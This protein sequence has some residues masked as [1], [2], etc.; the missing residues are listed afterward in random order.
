MAF[1]TTDSGICLS[2]MGTSVFPTCG[3]IITEP[4]VE[5]IQ[6]EA[7]ENLM[8]DG[9]CA[10]AAIPVFYCDTER[11]TVDKGKFVTIANTCTLPFTITGFRNSDPVRFS[12]FTEENYNDTYSSGNTTQLPLT[13]PPYSTVNIPTFFHPLRSELETGTAGT[14]ENMIGDKFGAKIEIYPGIPILNCSTDEL[15]CD[16]FFTLTGQLI[17]DAVDVPDF[18][19]NNDNFTTPDVSTLATIASYHCLQRTPILGLIHPWLQ[20]PNSIMLQ[21][22]R[23]SG[24]ADFFPDFLGDDWFDL[25]GDYGISGAL[26]TFHKLITETMSQPTPWFIEDLLGASIED[27]KV[28]E[29][30]SGSYQAN[31]YTTQDFGGG[32]TF[33]G[34][35]FE[36]LSQTFP[37]STH[38]YTVFFNADLPSA[39]PPDPNDV[40][41]FI[42]KSGDYSEQPMCVAG[43]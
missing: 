37:E 6:T 22:M 11:E 35:R 12:I 1:I 2:P 29:F 40:R 30:I 36:I 21:Y 41:M 42:V 3:E 15:N 14:Y 8:V 39:I 32:Y 43:T 38:N 10:Q 18:L 34:M 5:Y 24:A 28:G 23:I 4:G 7:S 27:Y 17:C 26:G 20:S 31:N 16:A 19:S 13:L 9:A 33:T 25:Y